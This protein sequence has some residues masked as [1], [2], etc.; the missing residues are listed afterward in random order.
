MLL[1]STA[2]TGTVLRFA[3][4]FGLFWD[5]KAGEIVGDDENRPLGE[6]R[7]QSAARLGLRLHEGPVGEAESGRRVAV[8]PHAL[9]D[10]AVVAGARPRIVEPEPFV[11]DE[12]LARLVGAPER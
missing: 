6:L 9:E 1:P 8:G 7:E 4:R 2:T 5:Q 10:E 3:E 12:R 11:D